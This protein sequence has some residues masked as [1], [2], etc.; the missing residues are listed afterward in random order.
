MAN[1]TMNL[2]KMLM[3]AGGLATATAGAPALADNYRCEFG[4][5]ETYEDNGLL[6]ACAPDLDW[7]VEPESRPGCEPVQDYDLR[8]VRN[9]EVD[10]VLM[11][12]RWEEHRQ[13][14][15][16]RNDEFVEMLMN[17]GGITREAA[18]ASAAESAR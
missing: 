1:T 8:P 2:A 15:P 9:M 16:H 10:T 18:E 17:R 6:L 7:G 4:Y 14:S 5:S 3:V 12:A 13:R 11:T